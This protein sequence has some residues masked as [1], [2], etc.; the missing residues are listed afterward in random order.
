M[1]A[2]LELKLSAGP[3]A[4]L[5]ARGALE[6]LGGELGP[7]LLEDLRLMV[8]ELVTNSIRHASTDPRDVVELCA[9]RYDGRLRIEVSDSGP[10][11]APVPTRGRGG[12]IGGWG[13][14]IVESLA[15]RWGIERRG[16]RNCV[17]IEVEL[18]G[19]PAPVSRL[20]DARTVASTPRRAGSGGA[21]RR[22]ER[23]SEEPGADRHAKDWAGLLGATPLPQPSA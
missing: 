16:A 14:H 20:D 2:K 6:D 18:H 12:E 3:Q 17:W 7:R 19:R 4:A 21:P 5:D 22:R 8:S 10:A 23:F 13:L 15:D 11:F 9:W 1:P